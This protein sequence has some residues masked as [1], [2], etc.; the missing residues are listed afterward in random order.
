MTRN[1]WLLLAVGLVAGLIIS[2]RYA[3]LTQ[4]RGAT[5]PPNS[6]GETAYCRF[7]FASRS[8]CEAVQ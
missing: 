5:V 2:G 1:H 6:N 3:L 8:E 7:G 4:E